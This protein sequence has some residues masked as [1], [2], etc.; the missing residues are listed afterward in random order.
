MLKLADL[1]MREDFSLGALFV[2]P[3]RRL[4]RGPAG[5]IHVEPLT[6]QVFVVL[7]DAAGQVVTRNHLYDECWG[8]V[9]VG[10]YSLNRVITM[11]RRIAAK[12]GPG[13]FKIESIPRTGYRLVVHEEINECSSGLIAASRKRA[14][15]AATLSAV[16]VL[17]GLYCFLVDRWPKEPTVA[18]AAA[19]PRSLALARST[20]IA[21]TEKATEFDT[22]FRLLD[23]ASHDRHSADFVLRVR[24]GVLA[25]DTTVDLTLISNV[26]KS[27]LWNWSARQSQDDAGPVQRAAETRGAMVVVCAAETRPNGRSLADEMTV[28]LYLDACSKF[29]SWS[30][31]EL[32]LLVA[33]FQRVTEQAPKLRGAWAKLL[34]SKSE[35]IEGY[36]PVDLKESLRKDIRSALAHGIDIPEIYGARAALLPPNARFERIALSDAALARYPRNIG[37]LMGRSWMLRQVGR[38]DEAATAAQNAAELYPRSSAASTEYVNSLIQSGRVDAARTVLAKAERI[39]PDAPNLIGA[40]WRLEMRYGDAKRALAMARSGDWVVD[41]PMISFLDAKANPTKENIDRAVAELTAQYRADP[42]EPGLLAQARG[43]FGRPN[44]VIQLL[45]NYPY[46]SESGDGAEM[47]FRPSL[48]EVRRDRRFMQIAQNFGVADYWRRSGTLPDFCFEPGLPYDCEEELAKV[49]PRRAK[50][51]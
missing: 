38:M 43:E 2:S 3:A 30:G 35:A 47:L 51:L 31:A 10:D 9:H 15:T 34:I 36:P 19:D 16:L 40:R 8:G 33:A 26:D 42:L 28:K 49:S 12:V 17:T 1:A 39:S 25:G 11:A 50:A 20:G 6:M 27:V 29:E 18:F 22:D 32:K 48:R 46:G 21:A 45:L 41:K 5:E 37:Y 24:E 13:A 7:A 44:D 14:L 23:E 4:V